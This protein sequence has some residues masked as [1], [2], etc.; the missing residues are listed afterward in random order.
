M[1]FLSAILPLAQDSS[2]P[3][4]PWPSHH[5]VPRPS[6][7]LAITRVSGKAPSLPLPWSSCLENRCQKGRPR[8]LWYLGRGW[9]QYVPILWGKKWG[10]LGIPNIFND[11]QS[12]VKNVTDIQSPNFHI[13]I[14]MDIIYPNINWS[15]SLVLY[16]YFLNYPMKGRWME[17]SKAAC[18]LYP[19]MG[20]LHRHWTWMVVHYPIFLANVLFC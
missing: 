9:S 14:K 12:S 7:S 18:H 20:L 15:C 17:A 5:F 1:K 2:L 16:L 4:I 10:H 13:G 11:I 6:S 3:M 8:S 19:F